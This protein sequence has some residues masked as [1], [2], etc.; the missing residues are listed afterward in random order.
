[1]Q[2]AGTGGSAFLMSMQNFQIQLMLEEYC[3]LRDHQIQ[4][5]LIVNFSYVWFSATSR[6]SIQC[7]GKV[8]KG[9]EH[10]DKIKKVMDQ[11]EWCLIQT[12]L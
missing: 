3:L 9:M 1:M 8:T 11:M 2:L 4:I 12:T 6:P 5:V 7:F 10:I